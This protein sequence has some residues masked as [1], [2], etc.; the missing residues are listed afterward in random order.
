MNNLHISLT[1][2]RN[3]SRVL[4]EVRSLIISDIFP[5]IHIAS[6]WDVDL[7]EQEKI[8]HNIK[9][10][11]FRLSSRK[12]S[13]NLPFQM[14]KYIEFCYKVFKNYRKKNIKVVNIHA[15]GLLPL[16]VLLK[17]AYGAKLIYDAHELET[18]VHGLKGLRKKLS[19]FLEKIL[20]SHSD[21][22]IVVSEPIADWY[23]ATYKINRPVVVLN[24]PEIANKIKKKKYFHENFN[25]SEKKLIVLYQG[26]LNRGRGI[27]VL[28]E[29]F[30]LRKDSNAVIVFMGYG[31]LE[32][33]IMLAQKTYN[34]IYFHPAVTPQELLEYTACADIGV[35]LIEN[36]CLSH[37][38]CLPNKLFEY[39]MVRLPVITSNMQEMEKFIDKYQMGI[40]VKENTQDAVNQAIDKL[41]TMNLTQLSSNARK[42]AIKYSWEAQKKKMLSAYR[43]L[44]REK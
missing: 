17:Y 37:Y 29:A 27:E 35:S 10:K 3:E 15:L 21:L 38:Y 1:E 2:F 11:R 12:Y 6:L 8:D 20:I 24:T 13:K 22:V 23:Q 28:L 32:K 14:V 26:A 25:L 44:L 33:E 43:D 34:N 7:A 36:T 31:L 19:K 9:L 41:S 5:E 40:V 4:K 18:E 42:T 39:A 30:Q 16:G